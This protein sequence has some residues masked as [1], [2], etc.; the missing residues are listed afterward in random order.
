MQNTC[1]DKM[2]SKVD[3]SPFRET[4]FLS[5]HNLQQIYILNKN[6]FQ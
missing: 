2:F 3:Y 6:A 4:Y 5:L 1:V